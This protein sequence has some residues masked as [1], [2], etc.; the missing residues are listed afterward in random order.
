M[1]KSSLT[2][3]GFCTFLFCVEEK[4]KQRG[5][6][7]SENPNFS[8]YLDP[9]LFSALKIFGN[10]RRKK[11]SEEKEQKK[12]KKKLCSVVFLFKKNR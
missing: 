1:R 12:I 6:E 5:T 8:L 2:T 9:F 3:L 10:H 7:A 11:A 4:G